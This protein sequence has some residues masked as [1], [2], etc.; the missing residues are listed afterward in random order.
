MSERER[1]GGKERVRGRERG[2]EEKSETNVHVHY[3][4]CCL[5]TIHKQ[6]N[7]CEVVNNSS[8]LFSE[9][10]SF[11]HQSGKYL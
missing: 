6:S 11:L 10:S 7:A 5:L 9:P 3:N 1:E 2:E 4:I 8:C